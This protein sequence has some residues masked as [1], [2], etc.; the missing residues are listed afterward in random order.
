MP[1]QTEIR[2]RITDQIIQVLKSGRLPPWRKPWASDANA[3]FPSNVAS[4][5]RYSG[6]NPLLL[7]IGRRETWIP[8]EVVGH[9]QTMGSPRRQSDA[10]PRRCSA[11]SVGHR[12]HL[13]EAYR[14]D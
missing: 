3:G 11:G 12:G 4:K 6:V 14:K 2:R 9:V 10:P 1:S 7:Q 5:R 8:G 13:L